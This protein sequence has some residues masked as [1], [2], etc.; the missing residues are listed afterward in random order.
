MAAVSKY[1]GRGGYP[2]EIKM[3]VVQQWLALGNLKLVAANTEVPIATIKYWRGEPWWKDYENEIRA[4]RR[5]VVDKKLSSIIDKTFDIMEDR[6]ENGDWVFDQVKGE[7]VRRPVGFKDATAAATSL[8]QRQSVLEQQTQEEY[9]SDATKSIQDQLAI[10]ANEF[11]KFNNRSKASAETIAFTEVNALEDAK[12]AS[13]IEFKE[14]ANALYEERET[15]L[16]ERSGEIYEPSGSGEEEGRTE[17]GESP[18]G[19]SW[20]GT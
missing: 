10:L 6:L 1:A 2:D 11:A 13:A 8:M 3:T 9:N 5:F 18:D 14:I 12:D 7:I 15:G 19:E 17:Q 4:G 16:Q 20:E